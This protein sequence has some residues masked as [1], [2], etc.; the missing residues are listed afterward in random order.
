MTEETRPPLVTIITA[1][2]N[3]AATLQACLD[4]VRAQDYPHLEHLILDG[5]SKDGTL[6]IL[7]E[8]AQPGTWISESD[9][10]IYDAWNKGLARARG[11]WIAFVG[12]DDRLLPGAVSAYMQLAAEHPEAMY[13]SSRV[14]WVGPNGRTRLIGGPWRWPRFQRYMCTAHVG[15]MHRRSLFEQYGEYDIS[16]P[17]VADYE[18]LLRAGPNL[19]TAFLDEVTVEMQG[20]GNSD[21]LRAVD[22]AAQVKLATGR[23]T[24][25]RVALERMVARQ[26]FRLRR[27]VPYLR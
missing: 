14:R 2:F 12:A 16:L 19:R 9:R 20:G 23:R 13:L 17:I 22:E 21:N 5:G 24:P 18:M 25:W 10:G 1:T 11:E 4:S 27:A 26:M 6:E 8:Y 7:K 15:S 3:A